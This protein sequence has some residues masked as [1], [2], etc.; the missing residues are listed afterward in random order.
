MSGKDSW[1][2]EERQERG[3]AG[4]KVVDFDAAMALRA[5]SEER[6]R[7][8]PVEGE[9]AG[10][11]PG[12]FVLRCLGGNELG[13]GML[14]SHLHGGRFL[15]LHSS[16]AWLE[17]TGHHWREDKSDRA[18]ASVED[19][20]R[21][22]LEAQDH[23]WKATDYKTQEAR[24]GAERTCHDLVARAKRLRTR[25]GRSATLEFA[26]TNPDMALGIAGEEMDARP[27]RVA[28]ANGVMDLE[29]GRLRDGRREDYL[30]KACPF[31][32][33]GLDADC[34]LW[35]ETLREMYDGD[36]E[37]VDFL[38]RVFGYSL[39]G[40]V[41][42][43]IL[44][45]LWGAGRNGKSL[46]MEVMQEV[47]GG[48]ADVV[49][50]ELLLDQKNARSADAP[51][52][53]I[54]SLRG[55]R[56]AFASE[57]DENRRFSAARVKWL[58]GGDRLT[59]RWPND[60]RPI[61]FPPSHILFLSTNHKPGAPAQ[62]FAFWQRVLLIEHNVRF[63]SRKPVSPNE[64]MRDPG[65]KRKLLA[66][67]PAIAAWCVRHCLEWQ[68]QGLRVPG[69]VREATKR[70]R[71]DEDVVA[72]FLEE[73]CVTPDEVRAEPGRFPFMDPDG[74]KEQSSTLYGAYEAWY[75]R[76]MGKLPMKQKKFSQTLAEL[77]FEKN[78]EGGGLIHFHGLA[79]NP[80]ARDNS[81]AQE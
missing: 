53:T 14:Y 64:R 36:Q 42:D 55:L 29:T 43:H 12:D 69:V 5:K 65:R 75:N 62:D 21:T 47:W 26:H 72:Q 49:P 38:G 44:P 46:I 63:V 61:S 50:S 34:S 25:A 2:P 30:L 40:L 3:V 32:F 23:V 16:E 13:D 59:G 10:G 17:W 56:M 20:A 39:T 22:Y 24:R 52:P 41:E 70:W 6:A 74:L 77:G 76:Y 68:R 9:V 51:S 28:F 54:M 1:P 19:V 4:G 7:L 80:N 66:I 8:E 73:C 57:T 35:E 78:K 31:E 81:K 15:Y 18:R 60:R 45:I 71:A 27:M 33:P 79:L 11:P 48:L 58:S 37:M 67:A